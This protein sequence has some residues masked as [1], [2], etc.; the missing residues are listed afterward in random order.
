MLGYTP[1]V[2]GD[3]RFRSIRVSVG[4]GLGYAV[5]ARRGVVR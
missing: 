3:G 2:P 4:G 5:R 1:R